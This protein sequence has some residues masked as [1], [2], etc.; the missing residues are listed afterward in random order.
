[1]ETVIGSQAMHR[2]TEAQ[3]QALLDKY[4]RK[5]IQARELE[6]RIRAEQQA[7]ASEFEQLAERVIHQAMDAIGSALRQRGH[8]HEI[9]FRGERMDRDGRLQDARITMRV[10]PFGIPRERYTPLNTPQLS[11]VCDRHA[12]KIR[13]H[14]VTFVPGGSG[15]SAAKGEWTTD[16]VTAT[17]IE[18]AILE[19]LKEIL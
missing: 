2:E 1:M 18:K 17:F 11:F 10:Y 8:E 4:D 19:F 7:F 6:E 13:I 15:R 16:K 3:L 14:E 12:R 9:L 5:L